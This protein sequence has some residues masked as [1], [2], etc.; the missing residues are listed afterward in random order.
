V[1]RTIAS[2]S[3]L[4]ASSVMPATAGAEVTP[5]KQLF[6]EVEKDVE[7][8]VLDW[9][10]SGQPVVLLAGLGFDAHSFDGFAEKLATHYRVCGI[11]RRGFGA[12]SLPRPTG[13]KYSA[14][15]LA[16]D[17]LAVMDALKIVRPILVGHSIAGE[18]LSSIGVRHPGLVA[19]LVYLDAGYPYGYYDPA[20]SAGDAVLDSSLVRTEID[21]LYSTQTTPARKAM[22]KLLVERDLPRFERDLAAMQKQMANLPDDTPS[23]PDTPQ[24]RAAAKVL[25]GVEVHGRVQCPVLAFFAVP[26]DFSGVKD[27]KE[28]A[29]LAEEDAIHI[30]SQADAFQKGNPQAHLVRIANA[31]HFVFKSNEADVLR[32]IDKFAAGLR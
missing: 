6:V 25:R 12:S 32:E 4:L 5:P 16:D 17:V 3:L 30:G 13:E 29:R 15:R 11:S 20:T 18:E 21:A 14:H 23:P 22:L 1:L 10:G 27:A 26:H 9:G 8:E 31:S 19:G 28:R 2:A 7:L 24:N